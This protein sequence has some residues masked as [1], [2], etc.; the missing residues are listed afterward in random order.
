MLTADD[1][2]FVLANSN[3]K[4]MAFTL[5]LKGETPGKVTIVLLVNT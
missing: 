1:N 5:V 4:V 3:R 2:D